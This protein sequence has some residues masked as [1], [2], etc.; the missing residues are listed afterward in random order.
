[1]FIKSVQK[2]NE[3]ATKTNLIR[4][5]FITNWLFQ[6]TVTLFFIKLKNKNNTY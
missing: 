1:M 3:T 2:I 4:N 5:V 6:T